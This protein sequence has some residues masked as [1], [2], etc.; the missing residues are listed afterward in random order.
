[1]EKTNT[2]LFFSKTRTHYRH[3]HKYTLLS[4]HPLKL[5]THPIRLHNLQGIVV[6]FELSAYS[7]PTLSPPLALKTTVLFITKQ[8]PLPSLLPFCSSFLLPFSVILHFLHFAMTVSDHRGAVCDGLASFLRGRFA[9]ISVVVEVSEEDDEG[10]S[11]ADQSPLHPAGERTASVEGVAGVAD[12]HVELDHLNNGEVFLPPEV[13]LHLRSQC[14]QAIV[15]VH[16]DVDGRVDGCTKKCL[17]TRDPLDTDPPEDKH[18]A[19]MVDVEEADLVELLPQDE[20]DC[21]QEFHSF[22]DVVP[23]KSRCYP[24]FIDIFRVAD[25]LTEVAVPG[26]FSGY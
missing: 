24:D 26:C 4:I 1:M 23:P 11:V 17:S 10:D 18:G 2:P 5:V 22:G 15:T 12:G 25:R 14:C 13:L 19:V 3:T 20:K 7:F 8:A 16:E 6:W 21:I 9:S